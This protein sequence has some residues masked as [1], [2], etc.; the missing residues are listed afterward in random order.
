MKYEYGYKA[1]VAEDGNY[2]IES[3]ITFDTDLFHEKYPKAWAL[4]E[5][6]YELSRVDFIVAL[7]DEDEETLA[8]FAENYEFDLSWLRA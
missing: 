2:G 4:L 3:I 8:E 7:L 5:D 1:Y 6:I